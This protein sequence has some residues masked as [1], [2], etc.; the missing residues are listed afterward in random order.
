MEQKA[1]ELSL[2]LLELL[3]KYVSVALLVQVDI[4]PENPLLHAC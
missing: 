4:Y 1:K 2:V 3:N